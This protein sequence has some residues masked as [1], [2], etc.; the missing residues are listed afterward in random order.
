MMNW[1]IIYGRM[2][3]KKSVY[4]KLENKDLLNEKPKIIAPYV[5]LISKVSDSDEGMVF[6]NQVEGNL[7]R[8]EMVGYTEKIS[9]VY[10]DLKH[11]I[12]DFKAE[13]FNYTEFIHFKKIEEVRTIL[14]LR[15]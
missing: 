15:D 14:N 2:V 5:V 1:E 10:N 9:Q 11:S 12:V 8:V 4:S 13:A 7:T 6:L 3:D